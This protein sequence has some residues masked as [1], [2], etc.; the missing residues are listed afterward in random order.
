MAEILAALGLILSALIAYFQIQKNQR[1]ALQLQETHLRN[2]LK[3]KLYERFSSVL[4]EASN[5][6]SMASVQYFSV[7]SMLEMRV[8]KGLP[9]APTATGLELSPQVDSTQRRLNRILNVLEEYEVVFMRFRSF[10]R[11]LSADHTRLLQTHHALWTKVLIYLP[12]THAETGQRI[13][14]MVMPAD[15][16]LVEIERLHKAY[17]DACG[18][19]SGHFIDLQIEAQNELLGALFD[20][21][22]PPR[23]PED[24]NAIVLKREDADLIERPRGSLI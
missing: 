10:R 12:F 22:L 1:A 4:D 9:V 3:L 8:R 21:H 16:D 6:L 20:R 24:A 7:I 23:H 15:N 18:E 17:S 13:G 2:D 19:I 11:H 5:D 14:P